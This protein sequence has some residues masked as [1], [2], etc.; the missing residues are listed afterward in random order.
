MSEDSSKDIQVN[1]SIAISPG[2]ELTTQEAADI[3]NISKAYMIK[4]LEQGDIPFIKVGTHRRILLDDLMDYKQRRDASRK[5]SLA[6]L[7]QM[8]QELGLYDE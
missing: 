3:L 1:H 6:E 7:T 4:L 8:S 5:K 2:K